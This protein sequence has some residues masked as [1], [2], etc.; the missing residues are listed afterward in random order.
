MEMDRDEF[1]R[2]MAQ[3]EKRVDAEQLQE[4]A[5]DAAE[6]FD[7]ILRHTSADDETCPLGKRVP[8]DTE[9]AMALKF[10]C[11]KLGAVKSDLEDALEELDIEV[12]SRP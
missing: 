8:S 6:V 4:R 9:L 5:Y 12:G 7:N 1:D 11:V 2:R 3:I 10:V